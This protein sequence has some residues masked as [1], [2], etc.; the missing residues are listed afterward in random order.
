MGDVL[1]HTM[2]PR[3]NAQ[4]SDGRT[5][6]GEWFLVFHR[7]GSLDPWES[8]WYSMEIKQHEW[9]WVFAVIMKLAAF[10]KKMEMRAVVDWSLRTAKIRKPTN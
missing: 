7:V 2:A 9:P 3:F 8:P 1:Q 4:A 10:A 6:I 5:G